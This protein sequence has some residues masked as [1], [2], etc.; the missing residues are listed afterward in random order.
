MEHENKARVEEFS[1]SAEKQSKLD[2]SIL[3]STAKHL[4][5]TKGV[6]GY[7]MGENKK[8]LKLIKR[9]SNKIVVDSNNP[10]HVFLKNALE[11]F[12]PRLPGNKPQIVISTIP[13]KLGNENYDLLHIDFGHEDKYGIL[14]KDLEI[15]FT[16]SE[17]NLDTVVISKEG[18]HGTY[19]GY[20][21]TNPGS[22]SQLIPLI[23]TLRLLNTKL[24]SPEAKIYK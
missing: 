19:E 18:F 17:I 1:T 10:E 8:Y 3:H 9:K 11:V 2:L 7:K 16:S 4:L 21:N 6:T 12:S 14:K 13:G 5:K 20:K 22:D 15:S 23:S 24:N